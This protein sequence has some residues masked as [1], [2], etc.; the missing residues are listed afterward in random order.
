[1]TLT[2]AQ[3]AQKRRIDR[4]VFGG[5]KVSRKQILRGLDLL[6]KKQATR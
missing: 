5:K 1:M 3:T 4:K 2:K 6:R